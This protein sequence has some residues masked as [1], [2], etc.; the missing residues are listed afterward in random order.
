MEWKKFYKDLNQDIMNLQIIGKHMVNPYEFN[1]ELKG[2]TLAASIPVMDGKPSLKESNPDTLITEDAL[3]D[4]IAYFY[5]LDTE[6]DD[7]KILVTSF[8]DP[9][10][11]AYICDARL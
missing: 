1:R 9:W 2:Y 5:C 10:E 7:W 11:G 6:S 4:G 3:Y 8:D